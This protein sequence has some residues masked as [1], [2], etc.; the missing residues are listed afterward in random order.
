M[1][2][3]RASLSSAEHISCSMWEFTAQFSARERGMWN[4]VLSSLLLLLSELALKRLVERTAVCPWN[5]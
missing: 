4:L 5:S 3:D 1:R 2:L